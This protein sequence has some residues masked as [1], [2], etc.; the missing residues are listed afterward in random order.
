MTLTEI[1]S[2]LA[3]RG[4]APSKR[5][6]QNF[7]FDQN[8]CRWLAELWGEPSSE[9]VWEIG[10]GLGSLT[11]ALLDHGHTVNAIEVD[12]GF[13]LWLRERWKD[14]SR[15][16][17]LE[18]DA[19]EIVPTINEPMANVAGNLPYNIST[20]L[21]M[22]LI[23]R[24]NPP[25]RMVFTVQMEMAERM[26]ARHGTKA[27]SSLS[28]L[29]QSE[30]RVTIVKKISPSVFYPRPEVFSAVV[31]FLKCGS[32]AF[33]RNEKKEFFA[34]V[35]KS[36]SHKRQQLVKVL[37]ASP[38]ERKFWIERLVSLELEQVCRAEE[39]PI[40]KWPLLFQA[41]RTLGAD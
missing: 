13:A 41:A 31:E 8:L 19:I 2:V 14:Q 6:G 28:V 3:E 21:V 26:A 11:E 9:P 32:S 5:F 15:F 34:F 29:V 30:Y 35:K 37:S 1:K 4:L 40:S 18:G 36:F 39:V 23:Q 20:P 16:V 33:D 25:Q 10:P 27:F 7:M 38:S 22:A 12:R 17:L 24:D